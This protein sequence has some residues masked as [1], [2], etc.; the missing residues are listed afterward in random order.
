MEVQPPGG[1]RHSRRRDQ[2]GDDAHRVGA[3]IIRRGR[4]VQRLDSLQQFDGDPETAEPGQQPHPRQPRIRKPSQHRQR[5]KRA[6]MF[7]LVPAKQARRAA[8]TRPQ[9]QPQHHRQRETERQRSQRAQPRHE[10]PCGLPPAVWSP[11]VRD[12]WIITRRHDPCSRAQCD[13]RVPV[14]G[15]VMSD[16]D[17]PVYNATDA[18]REFAH[19]MDE[20]VHIG[21]VFVRRRNQEAVLLSRASY[22]HLIALELAKDIE[23]AKSALD[24]YKQNGGVTL[25]DLK[26]ELGFE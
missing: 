5:R 11:G 26:A 24:D 8:L 20:A 15:A 25:D 3:Q 6:H 17:R 7:Q 21:P 22:D 12:R 13:N 10:A 18:R 4:A 2:T 19:L 16:E 23:D 1:P 9:R 14:F